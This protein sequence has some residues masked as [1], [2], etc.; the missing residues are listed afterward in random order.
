MS[1]DVTEELVKAAANGDSQKVDELLGRE[2]C[3][4][5]GVFAG[6]TA[7]QAASQNGHLEVIRTL[8]H[9]KS[10]LEIEDK[11]GDRAVHH[12]AFGDEPAVME[13]LAHAGADL[14]ARNKR[15]QT[16]LHIAVNKGH[17][18]VVKTLL[19]LQCH[20]SL[21]VGQKAFF[22]VLIRSVFLLIIA[23]VFRQFSTRRKI[24][25]G[26]YSFTSKKEKNK[27]D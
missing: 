19:D 3:N 21:Q 15:R 14:N 6:H 8:I 4:V 11:D 2:E 24:N 20:P 12:A 9:H 1:G 25:S 23:R 5:N 16:A 18:G 13:I 10:E 17:V 7:L 27:I 22:T 26:S